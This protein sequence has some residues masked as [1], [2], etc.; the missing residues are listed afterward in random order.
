MMMEIESLAREAARLRSFEVDADNASL[1]LAPHHG[2]N[3]TGARLSATMHR[4]AL[5]R[6]AVIDLLAF[7]LP[8]TAREAV[9]AATV[10]VA[11]Q[12][13]AKVAMTDRDVV[14]VGFDHIRLEAAL[15]GLLLY[16]EQA[17]DV[18]VDDLQLDFLVPNGWRTIPLASGP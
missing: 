12:D 5:R 15:L 11:M 18:S 9:V 16:L 13:R 6:Q 7:Q 10:A 14:E 1:A 2:A 8:R 4:L 3:D 17:A